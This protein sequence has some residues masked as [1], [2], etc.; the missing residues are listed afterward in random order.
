LQFFVRTGLFVLALFF[1][2]SEGKKLVDYFVE[3]VPLEEGRTRE[4]LGSFRGVSVGVFLST[5]ATAGAQV[6]VALVGYLIA[7]VPLL[8]LVLAATFV[9]AFVPAIGGAMVTVGAGVF[10]WAS[11]DTGMGIFLVIWGCVCVGLVDN[12]VKPWVAKGRAR[13][14]G[15]LVFFAMICGL[16]VF[17]PMGLVAG[18]MVVALFQ[19]AAELLREDRG[20]R[21]S[22][23]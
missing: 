6:L 18:P 20:A 7:D 1:C 3:L 14:P 12:L 15:S 22:G 21:A 5:L 23:A 19:V 10:L 17:G 2:L 8:P 13:L 11:G 9:L 4:L 16:A